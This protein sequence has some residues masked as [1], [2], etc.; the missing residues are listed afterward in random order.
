MGIRVLVW[1]SW[2]SLTL[3][4][5]TTVTVLFCMWGINAET[6]GARDMGVALYFAIVVAVAS[7]GAFYAVQSW[8]SW[9]FCLYFFNGVQASHSWQLGQ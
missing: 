7:I 4:V 9:E 1:V 2:L 8:S 5:L 6:F 3:A